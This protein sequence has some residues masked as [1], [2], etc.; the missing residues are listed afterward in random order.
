MKKLLNIL[1]SSA[2]SLVLLIAFATA[3]GVA[4]F[5]EEKYDTATARHLVYNARW[6]EFI[7]VFLALN[8]LGNIKRFKLWRKEK[9]A[10]LLFHLAFILMIIGAAVTRYVSFEGTMH[11]REGKSSDVIFSS[12]PYLQIRATGNNLDYAYD[13]PL[14]LS[15]YVHNSFSVDIEASQKEQISITCFD[16]LQN[17]I[18]KIT[19]NVS[20]GVN[21]IEL[22][23][24]GSAGREILLIRDGETIEAGNVSI[25][26][27]NNK[28]A[29][30]IQITETGGMML[31]R[32]PDDIIKTIM[33][34]AAQANDSSIVIPSSDSSHAFDSKHLYKTKQVTIK[35]NRQYSN[36][37]SEFVSG[38]NDDHGEEVLIV[39]VAFKGKTYRVPLIAG[40]GFAPTFSD[41][42]LDGYK[43][44]LAYGKKEI[45][46]PFYLILNDFTLDR[47]AGSMSPS[48]YASEVTLIDNRTNISEKRRIFMNHVLDH[49]GYRFFQSSYDRDEMGTI[50]SVNHDFSGTLISYLGYL[51][52]GIGFFFALI[53]RNS[54]FR[55]LA[56]GIRQLRD[57]R[58]SGVL[59][60][61]LFL[62]TF[63]GSAMPQTEIQHAVNE[64]HAGN[65]GHLI[66]Q[67]Y[68]GRFEPMHTLALDVMHKISRKD[69][70]HTDLKGDMNGVQVFMDILLDPEFWKNQ[71]II[72]VREKSVR[73]IL[74]VDGTS[75]AFNDFVDQQSKYKL[76]TY[77][78]QA[79]RKKPSEQ[80]AFDKEI[81]KLDERINIFIMVMN[82]S[83]LKVFPLQNS[84]NHTWISFTDSLALIPLKVKQ[85]EIRNDL[86]PGSLNYNTIM[87]L[88][89]QSVFEA[90][91]S[92]NYSEADN[93]LGYIETIQRQG[94]PEEMI[95]GKSR[96][97]FEIYYNNSN[98][99]VVLRNCYAV[100]SI[101]LLVLAFIDHLRSKR[102]RMVTW[103]LNFFIVLLAAAFLYHT[104]G[105]ALRWYLTGHAP[106]SNGYEALLLIAWGGLLAGF[107]FMRYSKITLASTALLA[108]FLLMTASHSS[109]DPQLTN[110]QP[111]LKSYW[112]IIHVAIITISFGFLALGFILGI[113]NLFI[114]LLKTNKTSTRLGIITKELTSTNEM[115]LTVGVVLATCGTFLGGIWANESWGRYWGWDAKETWSLVV[116]IIYAAIL[117]LRFVPKLKDALTFNIASVVGFG[118]VI[119]TFVGVNYYLS[120][121]LHSY[122]A[123]DKIVFPIWAWA[124]ILSILLL[125][126]SAVFK[127]KSNRS[128]FS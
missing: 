53:H 48:S 70:F 50:L 125:I 7:L 120:K 17:G 101:M 45:K 82:G 85:N 104:S 44:K 86:P 52:L 73:D 23:V 121:G 113:I 77:S 61:V 111:V 43:L 28:Q 63:R 122:A 18:R 105:L 42:E 116:V 118:T 11:I 112:L 10:V 54:R 95:P 58:K 13:R 2:M 75:A 84:P 39:N 98:I 32:S 14:M 93:I 27:N 81:I 65:F 76:S 78:E 87:R 92:G 4:T 60:I 6:F 107:S 124:M 83:L 40:T 67:T 64:S 94:T 103:L 96:I 102:S 99:F 8:F 56:Q 46:L 108:F 115:A 59:V 71:K 37:K 33:H 74:G 89:F 117:H 66:V 68:D 88:Y 126:I 127:E 12:E 1:F 21:M 19:E 79:F 69:K 31:I 36:A 29:D 119:M 5:I 128:P 30:A 97:D 26:Y 51:L 49:D 110:L 22:V 57:N 106:W 80:N 41:L 9:W 72:Y 25:A 15:A 109:Y 34:G 20:G 114:Y 100:L 35:F 38:G 62:F 123:D 16:Y 3:I 24:T 90:T 55:M 91:K 47:Y